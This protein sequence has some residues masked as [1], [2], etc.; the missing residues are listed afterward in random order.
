MSV[1]DKKMREIG[2]LF[3]MSVSKKDGIMVLS[4][5]DITDTSL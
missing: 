3:F 2:H 5:R 4:R 1:S